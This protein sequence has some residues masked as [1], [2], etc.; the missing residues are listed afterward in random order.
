MTAAGC[1]STHFDNSF[2]PRQN[3]KASEEPCVIIRVILVFTCP[4]YPT[5]HFSLIHIK[6]SFKQM[7]KAFRPSERELSWS[8]VSLQ[9]VSWQIGSFWHCA[10]ASCQVSQNDTM[11]T[12]GCVPVYNLLTRHISIFQHPLSKPV[13]KFVKRLGI[14]STFGC[15]KVDV[16][17]LFIVDRLIDS[18]CPKMFFNKKK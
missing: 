12:R 4:F 3:R 16:N 8:E 7:S 6:K 13:A 11:A 1:R 15:F 5:P 9:A 10:K 2:T 14:I 18:S 17:L